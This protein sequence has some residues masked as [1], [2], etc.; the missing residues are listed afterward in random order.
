MRIDSERNY[1]LWRQPPS[2][3][4]TNIRPSTKGRRAIVLRVWDDY[5]Y[6]DERR[7]WLRALIAETALHSA[8]HYEVFLLVNVKDSSMDLLDDPTVYEEALRKYVPE[9]FRSM[10][11]LWNRKTLEE[12]YPKV[13]EHGA[14]DQMYQALQVFSHQFPHFTHFWQLEMDLRFTGHVYDS[15]ETAVKFAKGQRRRNLWKRNGRFY[16]PELHNGSYEA[17]S[18][19][20][21]GKIGDSGVW[22][23]VRTNNFPP[24]GPEVPPRSVLDWGVDE[25]ADLIGFFPMID[26]IGTG[27]VYEEG[28]YGFEDGTGTPRRAAFVSVTRSSRRLLQ[29]VSE[30]QREAGQWL[31][32]EATLETFALLHGLKAGPW[33]ESSYWFAKNDADNQWRAYLA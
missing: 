1:E 20:V 2:L 15:L 4:Q 21:D 32:S 8:G 25:D 27:W 29:L 23:Y 3:A 22:G 13:E 26:P 14:Q 18:N 7:A 24:Q 17:F 33:W 6:T 10:A 30:A 5:Q 12:W 28:V 16:I 31:V 11:L 19:A 9:E